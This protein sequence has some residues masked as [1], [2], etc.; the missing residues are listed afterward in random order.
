GASNFHD[1]NNITASPDGEFVR[2]QV[3]DRGV[4]TLSRDSNTG[5]LTFLQMQV[6]DAG[7]TPFVRDYDRSLQKIVFNE[8]DGTAIAL[9]ELTDPV[10]GTTVQRLKAYTV[11]VVTGLLTAIPDVPDS[12]NIHEGEIDSAAGQSFVDF[13]NGPANTYVL[14]ETSGDYQLSGYR[15]VEGTGFASLGAGASV[16]GDD[17][18]FTG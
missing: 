4:A 3:G 8:I 2:V 14:M 11:D 6:P 7:L 5:V 16:D 18:S 1:L 10:E 17:F 9:F 12:F 15:V 13:A